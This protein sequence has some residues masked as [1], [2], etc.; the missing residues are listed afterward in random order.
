MVTLVKFIYAQKAILHYP[1]PPPELA[2]S[3]QLKKISKEFANGFFSSRRNMCRSSLNL[4]L[5]TAFNLSQ[6]PKAHHHPLRNFSYIKAL[7]PNGELQALLMAKVAL[8][9]L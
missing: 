6:K 5:F 9:Y 4:P 7:N 8:M 1:A 2:R 3:K